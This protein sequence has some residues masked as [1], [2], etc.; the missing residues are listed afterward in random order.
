MAAVDRVARGREQL[1]ALVAHLDAH[2]ELEVSSAAPVSPLAGGL[3]QVYDGS[4][5]GHALDA[6]RAWVGSLPA[7]TVTLRMENHAVVVIVA[8]PLHVVV[9]FGE[10]DTWTLSAGLR[11]RRGEV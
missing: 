9:M 4:D 3:C 8:A 11:M 7:P 10:D 2:P 6:V 1:R 5:Y